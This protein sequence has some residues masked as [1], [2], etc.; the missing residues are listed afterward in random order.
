MRVSK[1]EEPEGEREGER[2]NKMDITIIYNLISEVTFPHLC[3][4][5]L[6]KSK[7]LGLAHTRGGGDYTRTCVQEE[8]IT[9]S[10]LKGASTVNE[11]IVLIC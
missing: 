1:Q 4:I 7:S 11:M 2:T 9:G 8:G 5:L 10:Y 6:I 3:H